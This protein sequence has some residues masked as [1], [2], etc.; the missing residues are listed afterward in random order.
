MN[1][2]QKKCVA[3]KMATVMGEFKRMTLKSSSGKKV[4]S[5]PQ[6][7]AIGLSSASKTCKVKLPKKK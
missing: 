7:I 2:K 4:K 1:K 3:D 6:A 5:R